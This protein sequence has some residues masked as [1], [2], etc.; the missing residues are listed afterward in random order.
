VSEAADATRR[1]LFVWDGE[2]GFCR[3][4][5]VHWRAR[6]G[7]QVDFAPYQRV[8]RRFPD[9]PVA[10]FRRAARLILPDGTH[11][12]G[13]ASVLRL[14][15]FDP[16]WTWRAPWVLYRYVPPLRPVAELGYRVVAGHRRWAGT[17]T[18]WLWGGRPRSSTFGLAAW[19]LLRAMGLAYLVAF[20]SL[21]PQ[22]DGLAGPNGILP[23]PEFLAAVRQALG[24][25]PAAWWRVP[26]LAW[27]GGS[28]E[29]FLPLL[30][31][32]G[33]LAA[34]LLLLNLLP[35]TAA[36]AA[37]LLYL[38]LD[39][40]GQVFLSYQWDALLLEA[41]L[42]TVLLTFCL[43]RSR[44]R[45]FAT[46]APAFGLVWL[47]WWLFF[48]LNFESGLVKLA[49]GDPS[50]RHLTALS[51]HYETQPLP[52]PL[53]WFAFQLPAW[54]QH[55]STLGVLVI[56]L[57]AP[58]LVLLPRRL[59]FAGAGAI[60]ALQTAILL[61]GNYGFF[62]L[63]T[64]A[65][66]LTV[67]DDG[68]W[69]AVLRHVP[70]GT[71]LLRRMRRARSGAGQAV[72]PRGVGAGFPGLAV[73]VA[74]Y[75]VIGAGQVVRIVDEGLVPAPVEKLEMAVAPFQ[76]VNGYGLFAVMTTT[77]PEIVLE[78]R[79]GNGPWQEYDFRYKAD[80]LG[81]MPRQ[82][83]PFQPRLDW[84]MWFAALTAEQTSAAGAP[85]FDLWLARFVIRLLQGDH[86][87][88]GLLAPDSPFRQ[89]PPD[90]I[91]GMLYEYRFTT[92]DER[93]RTGDWWARR[94][95]GPYLPPV[96]IVDG[97]LEAGDTQQ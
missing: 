20:A 31:G 12:R 16:A 81:Q 39:V 49:S 88:T 69:R 36:I 96:R 63:L 11:L 9:V 95:V 38:S 55:A 72:G 18:H 3:F 50:W 53:S 70:G 45:F 8:A 68:A 26:T 21:L 24:S 1:P 47:F 56:E 79:T 40:A 75:V 7:D 6:V 87:V 67:F 2:C 89:Q 19:L 97:R 44:G 25:G 77:R 43:P 65:L 82:V 34:L 42:L 15:A 93:R 71:E 4:W 86:D 52:N 32:A 17:V 57:G 76:V 90:V 66:A 46:A 23:V 74:L 84:Q 58:V 33:I 61:T 78:G 51:Y 73:V 94:L 29:A 27:I 91:R 64:L 83:A 13:A 5:T 41:G 85:H 54:F 35:R 59:R 60:I 62:N 22:I 80:R 30:A 28:A 37:W 48:R 10:E 14:M 92:P